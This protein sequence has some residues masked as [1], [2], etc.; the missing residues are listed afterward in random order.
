MQFGTKGQQ[1][2][3][4]YGV[5]CSDLVQPDANCYCGLALV[6][7]I[8]KYEVY[9]QCVKCTNM[10]QLIYKILIR[11]CCRFFH[12]ASRKAEELITD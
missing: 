8:Y 7:I 4:L 6:M 1:W 3:G 2:N 10:I 9:A 5:E 12:Y 11:T